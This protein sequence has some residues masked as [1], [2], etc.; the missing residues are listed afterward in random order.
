MCAHDK[1]NVKKQLEQTKNSVQVIL[2]VLVFFFFLD[3]FD[4]CLVLFLRT[5]DINMGINQP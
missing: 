3:K 5:Q 4:E 1:L 2:I